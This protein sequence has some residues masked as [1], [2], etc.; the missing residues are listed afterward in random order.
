[1]TD[2]LQHLGMGFAV[3]LTPVNLLY[4]LIGVVVGTAIGVLPGIGP[5]TTVAMLVPLTF[6]MNPTA[7]IMLAGLARSQHGGPPQPSSSTRRE[8]RR[9]S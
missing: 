2:L 7:L 9:R 5:V 8:S 4:C 3:A 1:V 6:G